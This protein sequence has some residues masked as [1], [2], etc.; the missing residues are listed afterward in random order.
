MIAETLFRIKGK[1]T[2]AY[3]LF[4]HLP[5]QYLLLAAWFQGDPHQRDLGPYFLPLFPIP[6]K[7][8]TASPFAMNRLESWAALKEYVYIMQ[9]VG[10]RKEHV[11]ASFIKVK[12]DLR[13]ICHES[14]QLSTLKFSPKV[15]QLDNWHPKPNCSP[16]IGDTPFS[17]CADKRFP[18]ITK[19]IDL[20]WIGYAFISMKHD[21]AKKKLWSSLSLD[22]IACLLSEQFLNILPLYINNWFDETIFIMYHLKCFAMFNHYL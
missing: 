8:P 14:M 22:I 12:R 11:H 19:T 13:R 9:L 3:Q 17:T 20:I 5:P 7:T 4:A 18:S 21:V 10:Y 6:L 15:Y 16:P 2:E 1:A